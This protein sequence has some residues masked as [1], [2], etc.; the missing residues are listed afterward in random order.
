MARVEREQKALV[1][2]GEQSIVPWSGDEHRLKVQSAKEAGLDHRDVELDSFTDGFKAGMTLEDPDDGSIVLRGRTVLKKKQLLK[3]LLPLLGFMN[4]SRGE[5]ALRIHDGSFEL[6]VAGRVAEA[7]K[8][9]LDSAKAALWI[10]SAAALFGF[11]GM[12]FV[13][14]P[15][16]AIVWSAG[17]IGGGLVLRS[18][19]VNGRS[20]M[21]ARLAMGLGMLAQEEGL[22][23]PPDEAALD[24]LAEA[25]AE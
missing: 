8:P 10:F 13:W 4:V 16:A 2:R 12:K 7:A 15:I 1:K 24:R 21:G 3:S 5:A 6:R 19:L 17:L 11:L 9:T 14:A 18:G 20:R 25:K 22:V 23:L